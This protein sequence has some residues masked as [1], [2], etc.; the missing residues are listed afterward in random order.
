[1]SMFDS[2]EVDGDGEPSQVMDGCGG[3][4]EDVMD[5]NGAAMPADPVLVQTPDGMVVMDAADVGVMPSPGDIAQARHEL[6][7]ADTAPEAPDTAAAGH[8]APTTVEPATAPPAEPATAP[9]EEAPAPVAEGAPAPTAEGQEQP[10]QPE[11][12]AQQLE[13][14]KQDAQENQE[15]AQMLSQ[16]AEIRHQTSMG[17]IGNMRA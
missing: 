5:D 17:I 3:P 9:A 11:D 16:I 14:L 1:M 8:E 15:T 2:F 7:G 6:T 10:A 13:Q 4:P 12:K